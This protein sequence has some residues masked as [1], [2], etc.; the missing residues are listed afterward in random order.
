MRKSIPTLALVGLLFLLTSCAT[1]E[2]ST[3]GYQKPVAMSSSLDGKDFTVV[4][5]FVRKLRAGWLIYMLIPVGHPDLAQVINQEVA[6][7]GGDGVVNLK[8]TTQYDAVD[9]VISVLVGGLYNTRSIIVEGDVIKF[10]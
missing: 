6:A 3:L 7:A 4:K 1:L 8:I 5:H 10:K 9:V 2:L